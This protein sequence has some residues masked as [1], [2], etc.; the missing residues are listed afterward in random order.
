MNFYYIKM[1]SQT[2]IYKA[3]KF[4]SDILTCIWVIRKDVSGIKKKKW[5]GG[6][7]N[8]KPKATV[9]MLTVNLHWKLKILWYTRYSKVLIFC[10]FLW[11]LTHVYSFWGYHRSII[12]LRRTYAVIFRQIFFLSN[13]NCGTNTSQL[14]KIFYNSPWVSPYFFQKD[15]FCTVVK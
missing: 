13:R 15:V 5:Q 8:L 2:K 14:S 12:F 1:E 7:K 3:Y 9:I 10:N 11:H 6:K 4:W